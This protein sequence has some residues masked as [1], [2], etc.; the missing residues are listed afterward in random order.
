MTDEAWKAWCGAGDDTF[1][2]GDSICAECQEPADECVCDD[3]LDEDM[4]AFVKGQMAPEPP[5]LA[6]HKPE[7]PHNLLQRL[8]RRVLG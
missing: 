3:E 8:W 7:K 4:L 2:D 6:V 1:V 5:T